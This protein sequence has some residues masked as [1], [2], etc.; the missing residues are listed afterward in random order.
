LSYWSVSETRARRRWNKDIRR[1]GRSFAR[2]EKILPFT[3][4][5]Y[6]VI[7]RRMEK[8]WPS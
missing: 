4:G 5:I 6:L 7:K 2:N 8:S 1:L 3:T